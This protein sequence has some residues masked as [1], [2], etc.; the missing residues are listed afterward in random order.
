[1]SFL[2][3]IEC[4]WEGKYFKDEKHLNDLRK[5]FLENLES[6]INSIESDMNACKDELQRIQLI[7]KLFQWI[8]VPQYYF[9]RKYYMSTVTLY[10]L[11]CS[12]LFMLTVPS[13]QK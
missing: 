3:E 1:M 7:K 6:N 9:E 4:V 10:N 2:E 12:I 5:E 8:P 11:N 13:Q